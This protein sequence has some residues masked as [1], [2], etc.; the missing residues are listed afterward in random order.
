[1]ASGPIATW[2]MKGKGGSS[3]KFPLPRVQ[4]LCGWWLQP[5]NQKTVASWQESDDKRRQCVEKQ[6]Y[7]SANKGPYSQSCGLP[8]DHAQLWELDCKGRTPKNWCLQTVVLEKTPES[9]L[10]SKE[11]KPVNLKGDQ[12]WVFIE[13]TDAE[14][15]APVFWLSD[16]N[17]RLI[18][19]SPYCWERLRAEEEGI[20]GWDG[21]M[22]SLMQWIWTWA[23]FGRWWGTGRPGILQS[24]GLKRVGLDWAT[25][26]QHLC[27]YF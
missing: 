13:R 6:R 7:H 2:Q 16:A 1:M 27:I 21:W 23:N 5:W 11:T 15:E 20:R 26:Q 18:K 10:D 24:M 17:S 3:D 14:A 19:K 22:A 25:E 12:P 9:P 8:S 4:N